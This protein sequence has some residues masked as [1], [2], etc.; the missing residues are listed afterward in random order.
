M[1]SRTVM[2]KSQSPYSIVTLEADVL[3]ALQRSMGHIVS[4]A[5]RGREVPWLL[6]RL[7]Q[8]TRERLEHK[9]GA[10]AGRGVLAPPHNFSGFPLQTHGPS[11]GH[12]QVRV[13]A[14]DCLNLEQPCL[15][16][17]RRRTCKRKALELR[18]GGKHHWPRADIK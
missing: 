8:A 2:L 18:K 10:Q 1:I 7:S 3:D 12:K 14:T 16:T 15:K 5:E 9:N 11:H 4:A 6:Q 17:L 13:S